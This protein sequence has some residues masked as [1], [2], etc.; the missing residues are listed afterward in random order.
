MSD[1]KTLKVWVWVN[2][3]QVFMGEMTADEF[4]RVPATLYDKCRPDD[5]WV[6]LVSDLTGAEPPGQANRNDNE[7][8]QQMTR[9]L[10]PGLKLPEGEMRWQQLHGVRHHE[11]PPDMWDGID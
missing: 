6:V 7:F 3:Q 8:A 1:R 9:R 2:R 11:A 10:F 4:G 5:T